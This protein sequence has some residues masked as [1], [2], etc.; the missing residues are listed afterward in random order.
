MF[1]GK[2]TSFSPIIC[3]IILHNILVNSLGQ[4]TP[5][6]LLHSPLLGL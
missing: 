3:P 1:G 5:S 4:Y 6:T 2:L